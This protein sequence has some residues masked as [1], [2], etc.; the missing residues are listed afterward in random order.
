MSWGTV[1]FETEVRKWLMALSLSDQGK[2]SRNIVRLSE[3]GPL[4]SF[5][6]SSQLKGKLRELRFHLTN[7]NYRITYY[8]A[9]H[10]KIILLTVFQKT[11][12]NESREVTR[13]INAHKRHIQRN[14]NER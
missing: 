5:P 13:A 2:V 12:R 10:Q 4:L 3:M 8:I 14:T 9:P 6:F 1:H 7:G 11:K